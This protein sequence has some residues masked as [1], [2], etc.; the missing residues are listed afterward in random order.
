MVVRRKTLGEVNINI[1]ISDKTK[2][3][4]KKKGKRKATKR[5]GMVLAPNF[6]SVAPIF[7][8]YSFGTAERSKQEEEQFKTKELLLLTQGELKETKQK[9]LEYKPVP[10]VGRSQAP[11][12]IQGKSVDFSEAETIPTAPPLLKRQS[13]E[14]AIREMRE[15]KISE[16]KTMNA[17]AFDMKDRIRLA[18]A[19]V[20]QPSLQSFNQSQSRPRPAPVETK[21]DI[22]IK[23]TTDEADSDLSNDS[24]KPVPDKPPLTRQVSQ[25]AIEA[26]SLM[27]QALNQDN[28]QTKKQDQELLNKVMNKKATQFQMGETAKRESQKE[29]VSIGDKAKDK[30]KSSIQAELIQKSFMKEEE[31]KRNKERSR[32]PP[33]LPPIRPPRPKYEPAEQSSEEEIDF[34]NIPPPASPRTSYGPADDEGFESAEEEPVN[35]LLAK[36]EPVDKPKVKPSLLKKRLDEQMKEKPKPLSKPQEARDKEFE[37]IRKNNAIRQQKEIDD[38]KK[39]LDRNN[40]LIKDFGIDDYVKTVSKTGIGKLRRIAKMYGIKGTQKYKSG[41]I[42]ELGDILK[43]KLKK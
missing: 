35:P 22:N 19:R 29:L 21:K 27:K 11:K 24:M 8:A 13:S 1:N 32:G 23:Q 39:E 36:E 33:N 18:T 17:E 16:L 26:I 14:E 42:E 40:A 10:S 15:Q 37:E 41:D 25:D 6:G 3:K 34:S 38:A 30:F 5:K 31:D 12:T 20:S 28:I 4:K 2:P 9:L 7:P 43:K